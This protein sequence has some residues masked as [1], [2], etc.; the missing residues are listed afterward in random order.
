MPLDASSFG[1]MPVAGDAAPTSMRSFPMVPPHPAP[2]D[3]ASLTNLSDED[4]AKFQRGEAPPTI[5][6]R[7]GGGKGGA[8]SLNP[9]DFGLLPMPMADAAPQSPQEQ[10]EQPKENFLTKF[11]GATAAALDAIPRGITGNLSDYVNAAAGTPFR[12]MTGEKTPEGVKLGFQGPAAAFNQGLQAEKAQHQELASRYPIASVGGELMGAAGTGVAMAPALAYRGAAAAAPLLS[13]AGNVANYLGRNAAFG[14]ATSEIAGGDP[15]TGAGVATGVAAAIPGVAKGVSL[16][17]AP[18]R[19]LSPLW[20]QA[21]RQKSVQQNLGRAIEGAPIQTSPVGPLD[22]AQA[23]GSPAAAAKVRYAQGIAPTEARGLQDAQAG[24]ARGEIGQ[25]GN[26]TSAADNSAAGTQAIRDLARVSR[27]RERELWN[28]PA[29]TDFMM[30]TTAVKNAVQAALRSIQKDDPGLMLGMVGPI[31]QA[32]SGIGM[33]PVRANMQ[34]INSFIGTLKAVARRPPPENAR[35]GA[36][37]SRLVDAADKALDATVASSGAPSAVRSAYQ[38]ARDFTRERATIL[39]TQDMRSVLARNPS[40]AYIADPSEGLRRFFNFSNGSIEG[41]QNVQQLIEFADKIKGAV[42]GRGGQAEAIGATRDQ[43]RDAARGYVASALTQ[44]S[45]LGEGQNFNPKLMQDFLRQNGAWMKRSGLFDTKQID[46]AERLMD[47]AG[48]LRRTEGLNPQGGS[49]TQ[50]R[51]EVAKTFI[52]QIMTPWVRRLGELGMMAAGGHAHGGM[53]A[54]A[55]GMAATATEA[56]FHRAEGA[57]RD[58]M[59]SAV[60]DARV[61]KDLMM[62]PTRGNEGFLSPQA[63]DLLGKLR[64]SIGSDVAPHFS[65]R[66]SEPATQVRQ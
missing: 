28:N 38:T 22:L 12:M 51:Q 14:G 21:A 39:G 25:I 9:A 65:A 13:K 55:G 62:R 61:A 48:M 43:L 63:R 11:T 15:A 24:A 27:Q 54:V 37:A 32:A 2:D 36:L 20:S 60:L 58:M 57:M 6:V 42:L 18:A 59:A 44:A 4:Y 34:N 50:A 49:P 8:P 64:L 5:S 29:L 31:R 23:T 30:Q 53:G 19:A 33:L 56:A 52:D 40:G 41:P 26:A 1:L 7:P 17:G 35:A 66:Q 10:P 47:Y 45:R 3:P 46:A 16:L